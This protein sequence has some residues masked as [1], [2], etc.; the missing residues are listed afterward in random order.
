ML[1]DIKK[2]FTEN[3]TLKLVSLVL[4]VLVWFYIVGELKKGSVEERQLLK[5]LLP[6]ESMSAKK[7]TI[8]PIFIGKPRWGYHIV[9]DKTIIVPE[10]CIVVGTRELLEKT[11]FIYTMPVD[12]DGAYKT[13]SKSVP[14]NPISPGIYMDETLVQVTVPVESGDK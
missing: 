8:R 14:L 1:K 12:I 13:F 5:Q 10:Y 9:K 4:A 7:L 11:R 2:L 6:T 3:I